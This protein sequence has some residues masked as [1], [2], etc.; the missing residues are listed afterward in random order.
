MQCGAVIPAAGQARRFGKGDKTFTVL[1]GRPLLEWTLTALIDSGAL[2]QIVIVV[3]ELNHA[4]VVDLITG[5][6]ASIPIST[7]PGGALRMDSV[8]AGVRSLGEDCELV[9]IH[10]AA[11]PLV[12]IDLIRSSIDRA[13]ELGAVIP[14]VG[15]TDTIKRVQNDAV[16]E[17][18]DRSELV[19]VQT[20]QVFRREWLLASYTAFEQ[21]AEATDEAAI[22]EHAGYPVHVIHG[23]QSNIKVTGP[24]DAEYAEFLLCRRESAL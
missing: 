17:T 4:P 21:Q 16:T 6:R 1:A 8:A 19:A 2:S 18:L 9:L 3:S 12:S 7:V 10:D 24:A 14:A 15:V 13:S 20:P 5:L 11:R 23:E 22:L